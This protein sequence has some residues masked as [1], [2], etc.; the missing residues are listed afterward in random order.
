MRTELQ[1]MRLA[2]RLARRGYGVTSPNPM[3]ERSWSNAAG[4]SAAV[5]TGAPA[6]PTRK[7]RPFG[8]RSNESKASK[9]QRSTSL[10]SLCTQA[11]H[12]LH[13]GD[14]RRW[15][16]KSDGWRH[17]SKP[18]HLAG[19]FA[20]L[21]EPLL[22]CPLACWRKNARHL[23]RLSII[24]SSMHSVRHYQS[25]MSLDGKIATAAGDRNGL[26]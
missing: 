3:E 15:N 17:R 25:R 9:A 11:A 21:S 13:P 20:I 7:S 18:A 1:Y 24:G 12:R 4:S 23:T 2:L 16:Q 6:R 22:R 26:Q 10:W 8:M 5:G 19:P 14:Y